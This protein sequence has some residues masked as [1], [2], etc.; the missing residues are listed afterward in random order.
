MIDIKNKQGRLNRRIVLA[1][2]GIALVA[3]ACFVVWFFIFR[4]P[5]IEEMNRQET[6]HVDGTSS[7]KEDQAPN[8]NTNNGTLP[9]KNGPDDE[10]TINTDA[11]TPQ[12]PPEKPQIQRAGGSP[13]IRVVA[14]F[15]KAS[16]G[17]CEIV[18]KNGSVTQTK[19]ANI[20]VG[21]SY[22]VCSVDISRDSLQPQDG[23]VLTVIHHIG[24]AQT[25]SDTVGL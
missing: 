20:T 13:T 5:S 21:S 18:L 7:I 4:T 12:V 11:P 24:D 17:Y 15:Q 9:N 1:I 2:L 6:N 23:W 10:S 3:A 16:D 14:T 22:Y 19:K 8:D 25:S